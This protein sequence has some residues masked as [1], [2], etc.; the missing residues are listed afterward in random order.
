LLRPYVFL[1]VAAFLVAGVRDIG[2]RRTA[3]IGVVVW[4]LAWREPRLGVALY[5][6]G[7]AFNLAVTGWIGESS[8]DCSVSAS[9]GPA[10][11]PCRSVT[12]A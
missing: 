7:I 8:G 3:V 4:P 1:F 6:A 11:L 9:P 5:Y 12:S 2:W 10:R